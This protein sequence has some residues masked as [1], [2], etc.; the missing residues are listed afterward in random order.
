MLGAVLIAAPE[1]NDEPEKFDF[2]SPEDVLIEVLAHDNADQTLP[3]WQFHTLETCTVI[4]GAKG[5]TGAA[6][7][8]QSYGGFLDYTVQDLITCPG[9]GWWIV[10]GVTGDYRKGDGWTTDDDMR[11]DCKGFRRATTAEIAEA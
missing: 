5:V 2:D 1:R 11:F 4:G 7:Y 3:H 8:E 6:S 10:E 9:E